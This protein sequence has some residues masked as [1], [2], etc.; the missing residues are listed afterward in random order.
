MTIHQLM[1]KK[2]LTI[3]RL[4]KTSQIPYATLND[5]CNNKV[6][7]EKCSAETVYR[8]ARAL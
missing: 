4:A 8:I 5:I 6:R 3:Y 7:L 1:K 2:Q